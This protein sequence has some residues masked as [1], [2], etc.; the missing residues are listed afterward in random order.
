MIN[1]ILLILKNILPLD[2]LSKN[3]MVVI[4]LFLV[5][6]VAKSLFDSFNLLDKIIRG[7]GN[8]K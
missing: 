6:I 2:F 7:S 4:L 5:F 3:V 1:E 8:E